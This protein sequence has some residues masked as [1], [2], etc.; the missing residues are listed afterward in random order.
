[1]SVFCD[2]LNFDA[3]SVFVTCDGRLVR[4]DILL[5]GFPGNEI[6]VFGSADRPVFRD[7]YD[8]F[9]R[10]VRL[11]FRGNSNLTIFCGFYSDFV[12]R[13]SLL[14]IGNRLVSLDINLASVNTVFDGRSV[15]CDGKSC[16]GCVKG[17]GILFVVNLLSFSCRAFVRSSFQNPRVHLICNGLAVIDLII[18]LVVQ[19]GFVHAESKTR[20]IHG[21]RNVVIARDFDGVFSFDDFRARLS[22]CQCPAFL[23]GCDVSFIT[24]DFAFQRLQLCHVHR[25][26]VLRTRRYSCQLAGK[27]HLFIAN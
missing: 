4:V 16:A 10:L 17:N 12:F 20:A 26:G 5:D 7:V 2:I 9:C 3:A 22:I 27:A 23:Q 8:I 25:I 21:S 14:Q 18:D 1:M 24:R 15:S 11:C 19:L 13:D 6:A